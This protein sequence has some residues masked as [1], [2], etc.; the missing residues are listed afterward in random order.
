MC[1]SLLHTT[2]LKSLLIKKSVLSYFEYLNWIE[3]ICFRILLLTVYLSFFVKLVQFEIK[4][5]I[6]LICLVTLF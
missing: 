6:K 4:F 3:V 1:N 5:E 2:A